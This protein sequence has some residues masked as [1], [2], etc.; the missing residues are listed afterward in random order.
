M[1]DAR[2]D[3]V[4]VGLLSE[5][6]HDP[7][8]PPAGIRRAPTGVDGLATEHLIVNMGPQHPSTHG[9]LRM[10]VELDGEEVI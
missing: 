2:D 7:G 1:S 8:T 9:V 5:G 6:S 3:I 10:L 4:T